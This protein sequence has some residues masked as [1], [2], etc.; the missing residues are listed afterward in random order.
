MRAATIARAGKAALVDVDPPVPGPG[1]VLVRV[2]LCGI[3]GSDLHTYR[4]EV[5]AR[6]KI[7]HEICGLVEALGEG[8]DGPGVGQRV[9]AE[10]F[11]HCGRCRFCRDGSYNL[12]EHYSHMGGLV[13]GALAERIVLPAHALYP[14]PPG[15]SD[16]QVMMVEPLAVAFRAV[17]RAGKPQSLAILGAG[18]VGLLCAAVARA[19]G[20]ENI[21]VL[22]KYPHQARMAAELGADRVVMLGEQDALAAMG[23]ERRGRGPDAVI[24]TVVAE[25]SISLAMAL[26]GNQGRVVLV[27][28]SHRA[29]PTLIRPV[30]R[31]ELEVTGSCCYGTTEGRPD[32][33]WA[34][35]LIES[36]AVAVEKLVTHTFALDDID[37]AF[38]VAN[39]KRT[40][41]IKVAVAVSS[42][43]L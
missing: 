28:E 23:D 42:G 22:A 37:A 40:G 7:G 4:G 33:A 16:E 2:G 25:S 26:P 8:A 24:D 43:P 30:V 6:F 41:S 19:R 34:L 5:A 13:H 9:C 17:A 32:F 15:L 20:V 38:R 39:D 11:S 35:E 12:C 10:C 1:Q 21:V 29:L 36:G 14:A 31:H 18:T 27:G 3:C